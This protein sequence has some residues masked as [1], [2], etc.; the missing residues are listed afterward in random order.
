MNGQGGRHEPQGP[1]A[2]RRWL[3]VWFTR[4]LVAREEKPRQHSAPGLQARSLWW[5]EGRDPRGPSLDFFSQSASGGG[6]LR[7]PLVTLQE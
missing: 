2:S 3:H 4:A 5:G 6:A 7:L 1:R